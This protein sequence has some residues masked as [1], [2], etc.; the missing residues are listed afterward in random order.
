M[1]PILLRFVNS[2]ET[3]VV[4]L[5]NLHAAQEYTPSVGGVALR[6]WR[7]KDLGDCSDTTTDRP[8]PAPCHV[9]ELETTCSSDWLHVTAGKFH[10][11]ETDDKYVLLLLLD[12]M[13]MVPNLGK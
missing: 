3:V 1:I 5:N 4:K 11:T 2:T 10:F 7:Q 13:I 12:A 8:P 9:R 6:T